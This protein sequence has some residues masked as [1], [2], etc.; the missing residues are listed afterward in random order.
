[1]ISTGYRT[2]KSSFGP[3]ELS[4]ELGRGGM[5]VVY[6]AYES[7]L[8]RPI[9]LKLLAP[10]LAQDPALAAR[11]RREAVSAARLRHPN[12]ALL[13]AFG[14]V[15]G[16]PF[17]AM[18]YVP[19]C[20]LRQLLEAGPLSQPRAL[21]LL[22][23]IAQAL[24]YAHSMGVV[25]GD[26]KPSNILV[27]PGDHAVLIDFGLAIAIDADATSDTAAFGTPHYM[28]PEQA[29]GEGAD[30]GSDQYALA[31]VAYELFTGAPPFHGRS[32]A[33]IV[34]AQ[35][36]A[37]PPPATERAPALPAA[38]D[39]VL[40]RGL[41]KHTAER[42]PSPEALVSALGLALATA[43]PR[44]STRSVALFAMAVVGLALLVLALAV[45][46]SAAGGQVAPLPQA[47]VWAYAPPLI[48]GP[49]PVVSG[50]TVVVGTL[51]GK[52]IGLQ[53]SD[54][55]VRWRVGGATVRFGAP[56]AGKTII[57]VGAD[58]EA[59]YGLSP[60]SGGT[61]WRTPVVGTVAAP[62]AVGEA[63]L[64]VTT[65]KGY[66]YLLQGENGHVI[67]GRPLAE[68]AVGAALHDDW[69]FVAAGSQL[70]ALDARS[71]VVAW[72]FA[73]AG[74]LSTSPVVAG[75]LVLVGTDRG[76]LHGVSIADGRERLRV[77]ARGAIAAA[78]LVVGNELYLADRS[79]HL[80]SLSFPTGRERWRL[81]LGAAIEGTPLLAD[82][83]L[84]FGSA[85]GDFFAV[86]A[87]RGHLLARL[88]LG[89]SIVGSPARVG[90]LVVVRAS[91]V[92]ALGQ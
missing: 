11:L 35:I 81:D 83:R 9:A 2:I 72:E 85:A 24:S 86:D 67:W 29:R 26:V 63:R 25:H 12:I 76:L 79:G 90:E 75:E 38:I 92:V 13:Y 19:G 56:A 70:Y 52:L 20:S 71:G 10:E 57:V 61:I 68:G 66:L 55:A 53:A 45:W 89:G 46:L 78:P 14:H 51:D 17:L 65:T 30:P 87:A 58:D 47:V 1:M 62:P 33:A 91:Q 6:R 3:Y 42:Y 69:V 7:E 64:A 5:G 50:D 15:D 31:A 21:G 8:E 34:H 40:R 54:G 82:G 37:P 48:G 28:A 4:G 16:A 59:V 41:A 27:A 22:A 18:E 49:S 32:G 23:Q 44:R 88:P 80:V 43:P 84:L 39:A 36:Y 77:Q 60:S 74:A 73:A